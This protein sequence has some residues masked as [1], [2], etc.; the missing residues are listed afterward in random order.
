M[1]NIFVLYHIFFIPSS[2]DGR[3]GCFHLLAIVNNIAINIHV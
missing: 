1:W 2:G 3:L